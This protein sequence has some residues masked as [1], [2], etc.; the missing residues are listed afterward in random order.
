MGFLSWFQGF[1]LDARGSSAIEKTL[2]VGTAVAV[3]VTMSAGAMAAGKKGQSAARTQVQ[4]SVNRPNLAE[5]GNVI[6]RSEVVRIVSGTQGVVVNDEKETL[7]TGE[8]GQ[9]VSGIEFSLVNRSTVAADLRNIVV[10]YSDRVQARTLCTGQKA[11]VNAVARTVTCGDVTFKWMKGTPIKGRTPAGPMTKGT[12][13][14]A[15]S[16][17][18]QVTV[19]VKNNAY[20]VSTDSSFNIDMKG[21]NL[22]FR[23][24]GRTPENLRTVQRV[25]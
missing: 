10:S 13:T 9:I 24:S 16:D 1:M 25:R 6:L 11:A 8:N 14:I 2:M 3:G 22:T 19:N 23:L 7:S 4:R 17:V 12:P 5:Q 15:K 20:Q 21:S 18:V